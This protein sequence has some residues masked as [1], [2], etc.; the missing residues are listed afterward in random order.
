MT[1]AEDPHDLI[2]AINEDYAFQILA[3]EKRYEM[4]TRCFRFPRG[5]RVWLYATKTSRG[6]SGAILGSFVV[7]GCERI[8]GARELRAIAK[9][10]AAR[11]RKLRDYLHGYA[12]WGI[13]VSSYQKLKAPLDKTMLGLR[14]Y[15]QLTSSP[16]DRALLRSLERAEKSRER[17]PTVRKRPALELRNL[18]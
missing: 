17:R 16:S 14:S 2:M 4:R 10:A 13:E 5:T 6:G 12:G 18:R 8:Q 15:R 11:V 1:K 3:G 9:E 7:G